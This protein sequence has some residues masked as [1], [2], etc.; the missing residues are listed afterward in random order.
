M[1]P[2]FVPIALGND[3]GYVTPTRSKKL[4]PFECVECSEKLTL[5]QGEVKVW[6]FARFR[7]FR[8]LLWRRGSLETPR[9]QADPGQ[10][11]RSVEFSV[12]CQKGRYKHERQYHKCTATLER[13]SPDVSVF[14]GETLRAIVRVT[15]TPNDTP[16]EP[17]E[18]RA[19]RVGPANV[20]QA[21]VST[22]VELHRNPH[23]S[24]GSI[25]LAATSAGE[26][27]HTRETKRAVQARSRRTSVGAGQAA[28][29]N[30]YQSQ[31]ESRA[32]GVRNRAKAEIIDDETLCRNGVLMKK[33]RNRPG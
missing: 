11:H 10:A 4:G 19:L 24:S 28:G 26:C 32:I 31:S 21:S 3:G 20:F 1:S 29:Q 8:R 18:S 12:K 23:R 16:G 30:V 5:R 2:P 9:G 13:S 25:S 15:P 14:R 27:A 7:R 17:L 22:I 33:Q 6:H